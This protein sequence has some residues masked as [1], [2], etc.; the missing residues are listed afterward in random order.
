[1]LNAY[2]ATVERVCER[3]GGVITQFLGDGVVVVFGGP[4]RPADDHARRA[5]RAALSLQWALVNHPALPGIGRLSAGI[6]ICTGDMVAGNI[7]ANERV[8]YTIVGDAVNQAARLQ[9]KTRDLGKAIL[10]TAST[11]AAMGT[12]DGIYL[13][14]VGGVP[15]RGIEAPVEAFAVEV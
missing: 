13:R 5:V 4:L 12:E 7:R 2:Y 1:M 9:V 14:P 15:L 3:E 6:G 10:V 11:R 8:V